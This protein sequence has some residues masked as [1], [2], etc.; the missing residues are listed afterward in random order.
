MT[1][2][3]D[4][5]TYLATKTFIGPLAWRDEVV[6]ASEGVTGQAVRRLGEGADRFYDVL[7]WRLAGDR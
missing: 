3:A 7:T 5:Q 1:A 2:Y 4:L 6:V